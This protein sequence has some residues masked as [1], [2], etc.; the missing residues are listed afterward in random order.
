MNFG[1]TID[2]FR[3]PDLHPIPPRITAQGRETRS[4]FPQENIRRNPLRGLLLAVLWEAAVEY[5]EAKRV[6][7]LHKIKTE[8]DLKKIPRW[9]REIISDGK[10]A[11]EWFTQPSAEGK[12]FTFNEICQF[13]NVSPQKLWRAIKND[14]TISSQLNYMRRAEAVSNNL[15]DRFA[16]LTEEDVRQIR[17]LKGQ[18]SQ[19]KIARQFGV[20]Q[21]TISRVMLGK[22]WKRVQ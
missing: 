22:T 14:K 5:H 13:C 4:Y 18:M 16:V 6:Q 9:D 7:K 8:E 20:R 19:Q 17:L 10:S 1:K 11:W 12:G 21:N 15:V 2:S 3:A